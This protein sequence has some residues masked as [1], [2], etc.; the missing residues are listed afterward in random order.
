MHK[1]KTS[2]RK[3]RGFKTKKHILTGGFDWGKMKNSAKRRIIEP[4]KNKITGE[5]HKRALNNNIRS[6]ISAKMQPLI[7][8]Y[9]KNSRGTNISKAI[10]NTDIAKQTSEISNKLFE[11]YKSKRKIFGIGPKLYSKPSNITVKVM[12]A[13]DKYMQDLQ[14][15]S[16]VSPNS[17]A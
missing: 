16:V 10:T 7:Y 11:Q 4:I 12:S 2:N 5:H 13:L 3:T 8:K 1:S 14:S 6:N 9:T 15:Q 17:N